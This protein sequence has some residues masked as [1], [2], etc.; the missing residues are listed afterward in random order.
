M[1]VAAIGGVVLFVG[2]LFNSNPAQSNGVPFL[3]ITSSDGRD[4]HL[5]VYACSDP[6]IESRFTTVELV[7]H[8]VADQP[9][10][11]GVPDGAVQTEVFELADP[12]KVSPDGRCGPAPSAQLDNSVQTKSVTSPPGIEAFDWMEISSRMPT[13]VAISFLLKD[14]VTQDSF[15]DRS[16]VV[17]V[18]GHNAPAL[19]GLSHLLPVHSVVIGYAAGGQLRGA[20]ANSQV[21][22]LSDATLVSHQ[23]TADDEDVKVA[24]V[25]QGAVERRD[26]LLLFTGALVGVL[27]GAIANLLFASPRQ[28]ALLVALGLAALGVMI[29]LA[30]P[31]IRQALHI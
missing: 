4:H 14:I 8:D 25:D 16:L 19:P 18:R 13:N 17:D 31:V 2:S 29:G 11:V 1:L 22:A 30:I 27:G 7:L 3:P 15:V 6:F 23:V 9:I 20:A 21:D 26:A 12:D 28:S 5:D 24:W 10:S